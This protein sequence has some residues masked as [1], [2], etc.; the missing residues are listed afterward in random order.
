MGESTA[1]WLGELAC[2]ELCYLPNATGYLS[3]EW[4]EKW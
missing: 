1:E 4:E 2:F 3:G